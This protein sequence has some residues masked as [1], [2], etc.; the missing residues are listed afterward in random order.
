LLAFVATGCLGGDNIDPRMKE[1]AV[2]TLR[3]GDYNM[4]K[5]TEAIEQNPRVAIQYLVEGRKRVGEQSSLA[6]DAES[7]IVPFLSKKS[8]EAT[9][10]CR[11][12]ISDY[13]LKHGMLSAGVVIILNSAAMGIK[14]DD[15]T[16][17]M[18]ETVK[19]Y[20]LAREEMITKCNL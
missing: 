12:G 10:N 15:K 6:Q 7:E 4:E 16:E 1:F 11:R 17:K 2:K 19:Q 9:L 5:Y 20:D 3:Y 14:V 13:S 18:K 8:A